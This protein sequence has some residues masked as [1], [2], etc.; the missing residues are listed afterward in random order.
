MPLKRHGSRNGKD[1]LRK[2]PDQ[3]RSCLARGM[4][5]EIGAVKG[6]LCRPMPLCL[7]RDMGVEM[8]TRGTG[9]PAAIYHAPQRHGS[10]NTH[11]YIDNLSE[12]CY[13]VS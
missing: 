5:V 4:G 13:A 6:T 11:I 3:G 2:I 12:K 10:R 1:R 8:Q 7:A 9:R